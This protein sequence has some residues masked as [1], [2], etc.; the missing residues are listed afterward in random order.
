M[1]R[2]ASA[3]AGKAATLNDVAALAGVSIATASKAL[4]GRDQVA[5]AT[6]QRV[7]DAAAK[8]SWQATRS[9]QLSYFYN[10]QYKLIRYRNDD[11][12]FVETR[13]RNFN[14]KYPSI[15]QVKWTSL[16]GARLAADVSGSLSI[17]PVDAFRPQPE[18]K[19]GDIARFDSVL[20]TITVSRPV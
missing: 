4:N 15:N 11:N 12:S 16:F 13:A 18:V 17:T 8:I 14:Y 1:A 10:L 9:S 19:E 6:R 20:N 3:P 2:S 7:M 5:P